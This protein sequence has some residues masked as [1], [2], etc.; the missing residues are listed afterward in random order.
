MPRVHAQRAPLQPDLFHP[1]RQEPSWQALST[2]IRQQTVK[3]LA[4]LLRH[5]QRRGLGVEHDE[6]HADE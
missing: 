2:P 3:L 1:P 5:H 4:Q 6:E